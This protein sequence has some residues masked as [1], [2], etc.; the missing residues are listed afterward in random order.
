[1]SALNQFSCLNVNANTGI[2]ACAV[3]FK[4][5]VGAILTPK[6]FSLTTASLAAFKTALINAS[7]AASKASRIYPV[8]DFRP[9]ADNSEALTV[10]TFSTGQKAPV[11]EG[12]LDWTF[13]FIA[14]GIDLLKKLRLFNASS[15]AFDFLFVDSQ[16]FIIGVSDEENDA[17]KAIPSDGGFFWAHPWKANDGSKVAEYSLQFCFLPKYINE[18]VGYVKA[19]FDVQST[20]TGLKDV[21]LSSPSA[22]VTSGSYNI[23]VNIK[24]G[25]EDMGQRFEAELET[26]ANWAPKNKTTGGAITVASSTYNPAG[27][28]VV[29]LST[30]DPDYPDTPDQIT[31]A[32]AAPT[33]LAANGLEGFESNT[34]DVA[35]NTAP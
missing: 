14:G 10:Q 3:N 11:R 2:G 8:Y 28:F 35:S 15:T 21:V 26:I 29:A 30:A 16:N 4:N 27:Y 17:L 12:T 24:D 32:L 33:V 22:N 6:G 5:I 31:F 34:V 23:A 13:Q 19:D 20:V 1:M 7:Q 18:L 9:L 25:G